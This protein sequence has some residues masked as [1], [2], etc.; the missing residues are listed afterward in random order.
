MAYALDLREGEVIE[1][2]FAS[3]YWEKKA[4]GM[5]QQRGR[6]FFTNQRIL[7]KG[8]WGAEIEIAYSEIQSI[9]KCC[10]GP[11]I[12][13]VPTGIKV[14]VASGEVFYLSVTKRAQRM[15]YIANKT[16]IQLQ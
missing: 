14:T 12:R 9:E 7:F 13:F 5:S 11:L 16:G 3:D 8:S 10:V 1:D 15:E 6:Y 4:L 2:E